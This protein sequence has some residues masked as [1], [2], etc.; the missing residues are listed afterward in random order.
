LTTVNDSCR[1]NVFRSAEGCGHIEEGREGTGLTVHQGLPPEFYTAKQAADILALSDRTVIRLCQTGEL[2]G[3]R[4]GRQWR[5]AI[6]E[7]ERFKA[8]AE[9]MPP[10]QGVHTG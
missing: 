3:A 8:R 9:G 7:I 1:L 4:I 2:V 10:C 5:I 6:A